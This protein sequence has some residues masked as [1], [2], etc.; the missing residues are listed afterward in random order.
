MLT[1]PARHPYVDAVRPPGVVPVA[2]DRV[3]GFEPDPVFDA[4]GV[5]RFAGSARL[6]HLH[7]GFDHLTETRLSG[8]L[9]ELAAAELPL[10]LTVH[11]LRNPHHDDAEPHERA[12]RMLIGRAAAVLTLTTG[13]AAEIGHRF[14]RTPQVVPHPTLVDPDR[15]RDVRTEPGLVTLHLK[16]LRR[17]L[18]DPV[19]VVAAAA[20][21]TA[22]A[23]GRLQVNLHRDAAA[24][25]RLSGLDAV[26]RRSD[27]SVLVHDR[28]DDVELERY[29]RRAAV[30]VLPHRWGSHSGWL[31]VARDLGTRVVAPD[32]GFYRDQWAEVSGYRGN[33]RDGL[34]RAS[35][36]A[37]VEQAVRAEP[38][39]PAARA[40]R[41]VGRAAARAAH[42]AVYHR[43]CR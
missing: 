25:R 24:D 20:D 10:V 38:I 39:P 12:L 17:N 5:D 7:F 42:L 34:D 6:V 9:D 14:G 15:T 1:I 28:F 32:C 40:G 43:G 26:R 8:W 31:E 29:L 18:Q 2:V 37:A 11:D 33:E 23:G 27:V 30:T 19:D 16:S 13:A 21:G 36:R 41:L 3:H 4:G 35:L 22:R